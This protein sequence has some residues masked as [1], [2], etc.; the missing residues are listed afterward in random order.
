MPE[1]VHFERADA[2]ADART[3]AI[4]YALLAVAIALRLFDLSAREIW[5]DEAFSWHQASMSFAGMLT[6]VADDVHPPLYQIVLWLTTGLFGDSPLVLRLPSACFSIIA[7]GLTFR[8]TQ[9]IAGNKVALLATAFAA[10]STFQIWYGQEA[11]MYSLLAMLALG[12]MLAFVQVLERDDKKSAILYAVAS[13]LLLYTHVYGAFIVIAQ[14]TIYGSLLLRGYKLATSPLRWVLIHLCIGVAFLPWLWILLQQITAVQENFWIAAPGLGLLPR[15]LLTYQ[16]LPPAGFVIS[17][18]LAGTAIYRVLREPTKTRRGGLILLL[19]WITVP[20][21]VPFVLSH[22]L[23]PIFVPR[24]TIAAAFPWYI[25]VA[26]GI[27]KLPR[28]AGAAAA[29]ILLLLAIGTL[30]AYY[31]ERREMHTWQD[32]AAYINSVATPGD[33]LIFHSDFGS[34]PYR[35]HNPDN[36]LAIITIDSGYGVS[37]TGILP[38]EL[39]AA[40]P[41]TATAWF[42][43]SYSERLTIPA[44]VIEQGLLETRVLESEQRFSNVRVAQYRAAD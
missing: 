7:V 17:V 11:R 12:S 8:L 20:I 4:F 2:Q 40:L 13:V 30:P 21:V 14:H 44:S 39:P 18:I 1:P 38:D 26:L 9:R 23:Q 10:V 28:Y 34:L 15:T 37:A 41:A 16:A 33:Y 19:L 35:Y 3:R 36:R 43:D 22:L 6:S 29:G 31:S 25:L 24:Y 32:T 42:I 5:L 27:A